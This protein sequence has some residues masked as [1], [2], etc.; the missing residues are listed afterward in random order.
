MLE[1]LQCGEQVDL[2]T[3]FGRHIGSTARRFASKKAKEF[4][5]LKEML[6]YIHKRTHDSKNKD[7][8][9]VYNGGSTLN[10][11]CFD[12]PSLS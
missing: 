12:E 11:P 6:Q 5:M 3:N 8:C 4:E 10:R 1:E 7:G 2:E 9:F